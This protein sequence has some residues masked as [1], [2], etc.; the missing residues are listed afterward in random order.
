MK[1]NVR[2]FL[3]W[4]LG[5]LLLV[6]VLALAF[7]HLPQ[8]FKRLVLAYG[9]F[10]IA[11]GLGMEW[12]ARERKLIV[13]WTVIVA[14]ALLVGLGGAYAGW[15]GYQQLKATRAAELKQDPQQLAMLNMLESISQETGLEQHQKLRRKL[16]PQFQDYLAF[17]TSSLGDWPPPWP[18][19]FWGAELSLAAVLAGATIFK[20]S[21]RESSTP[22]GTSIQDSEES[23]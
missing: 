1:V 22:D 13:N 11:C 12:L 5:S 10:G 14:A 16:Q 6:L 17:R 18:S 7:A 3:V 15:T 4:L 19:L 20:L 8:P 9:L 21:H 2:T 23:R